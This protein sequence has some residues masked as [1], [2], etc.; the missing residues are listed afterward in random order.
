M[1]RSLAWNYFGSLVSDWGT[2]CTS[3]VLYV[4]LVCYFDFHFG[5]SPK[6]FYVWMM[7]LL[8]LF[9][10][11]FGCTTFML[12][13]AYVYSVPHWC[14]SVS[15]WFLLFVYAKCTYDVDIADFSLKDHGHSM[16][17]KYSWF[18]CLEFA[19]W[20]DGDDT[21]KLKWK[22]DMLSHAQNQLSAVATRKIQSRNQFLFIPKEWE[23]IEKTPKSGYR[24]H[25]QLQKL[26]MQG[27]G[28]STLHI[29]DTLWE[30][31]RMSTL[32]CVLLS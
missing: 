32:E 4:L 12:C 10:L 2:P 11:I 9:C 5:W 23:N 15:L 1:D 22:N 19:G 31:S 24:N 20:H 21:W 16:Y 6:N 30:P 8:I 13:N 7:L 28:V 18:I 26:V 27:E 29:H 3:I 17:I 14:V 25:E